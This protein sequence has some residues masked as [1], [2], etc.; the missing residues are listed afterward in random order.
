MEKESSVLLSVGIVFAVLPATKAEIHM[1]DGI[2]VSLPTASLQEIILLHPLHLE[3]G[4]RC[5]RLPLREHV[6]HL[7]RGRLFQG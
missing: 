3:T 4:F 5:P 2:A 1:N 6:L 7:P